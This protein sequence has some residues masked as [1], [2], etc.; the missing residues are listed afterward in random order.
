MATRS[1]RADVG[2]GPDYAVEEAGERI[3]GLHDETKWSVLTTEFWVMVGAVAA[4]L[5][6]TAASDALDAPRGW[7]LATIVA[8]GYIVS[9]GIAKAGV[10]HLPV[11]ALRGRRR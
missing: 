4:V 3:S 7:L 8:T 5:I 1:A 2:D 9:R 11:G 6:A 10:G